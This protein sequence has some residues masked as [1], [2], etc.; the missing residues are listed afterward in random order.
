MLIP[1]IERLAGAPKQMVVLLRERDAAREKLHRAL[2]RM[3][4]IET[5]VAGQVAAEKERFSNE[6]A[7]NA[8]TARR[9]KGNKEWLE[10]RDKVVPAARKELEKAEAALEQLKLQFQADIA[11]VELVSA[12]YHSGDPEKARKVLD[13]YS[14]GVEEGI[15]AVDTQESTPP[16][17]QPEQPAPAQEQLQGNGL[18]TG[19]FTVLE[20]RQGS[21]PGTV[22]AWCEGPE[23]KVAVYGKNGAGK[24]L[25]GA[26]GK[27]VEVKF[28][29]G[30]KGL[31]AVGVR[32]VA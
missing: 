10:L 32:P 24:A 22:R 9:L 13:A 26:V 8:E 25:A 7:R 12:L 17:L 5:E 2:D 4:E 16:D 27:Q 15:E 20:A 18:E 3:K 31:I 11:V 23:G 30:D 14:R 29:R 1:A 21:S 28:R 6:A 19:T